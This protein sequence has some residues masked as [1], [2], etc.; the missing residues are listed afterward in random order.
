MIFS[1]A[2][3]MAVSVGFWVV[4]VFLLMRR[5][6]KSALSCCSGDEDADASLE[7][8]RMPDALAAFGCHRVSQMSLMSSWWPEVLTG[9]S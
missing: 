5:L 8:G 1:F 9:S 3:S 4:W 2:F 6:F 7:V